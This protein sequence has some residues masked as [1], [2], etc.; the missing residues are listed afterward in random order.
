MERRRRTGRASGL[1]LWTF[2]VLFGGVIGAIAG[3]L[4]TAFFAITRHTTVTPADVA[5]IAI[6]YAITWACIGALLGLVAWVTSARGNR[7]LGTRKAFHGSLLFSLVCLVLVGGYVNIIHL[8]SMLS[9]LSLLVDVVLIVAA[10][11]LWL[12]IHRLARRMIRGSAGRPPGRSPTAIAGT[13]VLILLIVLCALPSGSPD[14]DVAS[15][16]R[17]PSDLSVLFILVDATC[18]DHLGCYGYGRPTSPSVDRLA[19]QGVLCANAHANGSRTKETTAS[20]F[21]SLQPSAHGMSR[22]SGALPESSP[23]FTERMKLAG[24]RTAMFSANAIVSPVFGFDRGVDHFYS[25]TPPNVR[26]AIVPQLFRVLA[27]TV[28]RRLPFLRFFHAALMRLEPILPGVRTMPAYAG[29]S[30]DVLNREFLSWLDEDPDAPFFAYIHYMEPHIP[31]APPP[32]FDTMFD[33]DHEGPRVINIPPDSWLFLPFLEGTEIPEPE[34][35]N[36][37]AQYDGAIAFFDQQL[38]LL[39][40]ELAGRGLTERL[41]VVVTADHGEEFFEH[42]GWGHGHS[43]YEELTHIPLIFWCPGRI[44]AGHVDRTTI[45]QIDIMPTVLG[46]VDLEQEFEVAGL[47]GL[48]LWRILESGTDLGRE[49]PVFTEL[50][51][52]GMFMRALTVGSHK[53]VHARYGD[54]ETV[55]L[56]DLESDP[57]EMTD[58]SSVRPDVTSSL[59]SMLESMYAESSSGR[60]ETRAGVMDEGT[61]ERLRAL[62]YV[63]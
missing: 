63:E 55:L 10:L 16:A 47:T 35:V 13:A 27:T 59:L 53:V 5:D 14:S 31:Y 40:E 26:R 12:L 15:D 6:M 11:L 17:P 9:K 50:Y 24:Y 20:L 28:G 3:I 25:D 61:R 19:A 49:L 18:A 46:A 62:G 29:G 58:I 1:S 8:P 21:T 36:M 7:D 30:A 54:Q 4:E 60:L 56:F 42:R 32:P 34:R 48:N 38:G 33:P 44:P 57:E 52:G 22:L 2:L 45:R 37:V 41:L 39:L 23:S 43:M 51:G